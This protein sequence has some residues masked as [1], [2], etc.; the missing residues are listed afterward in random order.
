[1]RTR[2]QNVLVVVGLKPMPLLHLRSSQKDI[3]SNPNS[4]QVR[5]Y[6]SSMWNCHLT[7]TP[8][9]KGYS[10]SI[11]HQEKKNQAQ[12]NIFSSMSALEW[13]LRA[14]STLA[15]VFITAQPTCISFF[16]T[17]FF[18]YFTRMS[19]LPADRH[20]RPGVTE[21]R[22]CWI[23]WSWWLLWAAVWLLGTELRS[24]GRAASALNHWAISPASPAYTSW[25]TQV[26]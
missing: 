5:L 2:K 19:V 7:W 26:S 3:V 18:I 17:Y 10:V 8:E 9:N 16:I 24:S 23:L 13:E 6:Q 15:M 20:H 1:M 11:V 25:T 12:L 4:N 14:Q 22:G 21:A